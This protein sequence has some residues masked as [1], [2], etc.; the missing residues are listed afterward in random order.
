MTF[1]DFAEFIWK[2]TGSQKET[3]EVLGWSVSKIKNYS[4]LEDISKKAWTAIVTTFE[5]CEKAQVES[6]V[7]SK[8]TDVTFTEGLLRPIINLSDS[9][10][11]ELVKDLAAGMITKNRFTKL[12]EQ[13]KQMNEDAKTLRAEV[14]TLVAENILEEGLVEIYTGKYNLDELIQWCKD[15][16]YK[17]TSI[18]LYC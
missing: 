4:A 10:Q 7:T 6:G 11:F 17:T 8:V 14:G 9:Q 16:H 5:V 1:V 18:M 13:Y 12:A 2:Q 15:K 3:A